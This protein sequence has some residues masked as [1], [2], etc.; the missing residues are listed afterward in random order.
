MPCALPPSASQDSK[1]L[2]AGSIVSHGSCK[3]QYRASAKPREGEG[4]SPGIDT[5]YPRESKESSAWKRRRQKK[6]EGKGHAPLRDYTIP[7]HPYN[8]LYLAELS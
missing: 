4:I 3:T 7:Y 1:T 8:V 2:V 5:E 6:N